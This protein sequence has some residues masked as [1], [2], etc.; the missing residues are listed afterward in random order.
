MDGKTYNEEEKSFHEKKAVYCN[1]KLLF[2]LIE[3]HINSL[4][5]ERLINFRDSIPAISTA[6]EKPIVDCKG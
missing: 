1:N 5:T 4:I 6:S 3:P 2:S